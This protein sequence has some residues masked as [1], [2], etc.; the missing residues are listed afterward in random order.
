MGTRNYYDVIAANLPAELGTKLRSLPDELVPTIDTVFRL[1]SGDI[2][3][4]SASGS[5]RTS[6]TK[7]QQ[8]I[9]GAIEHSTTSSKRS[10][11]DDAED[12]RTTKKVKPSAGAALPE[13]E[14]PALF[15][16]NALSLTAPIRKKADITVHRQTLRLTHPTTH[17]AE[18]PPIPLSGFR[19]AFLLP[20]RGKTKPHWTVLL[21]PSDAPAPTGKAAAK[22]PPADA[23]QIAF[24]LDAT[25]PGLTTTAHTEADATVTTHPKGSLALPSLRTFLAHLPI[26]TLEPSTTVFRSAAAAGEPVAGVEAYRGAKSG[27]LWFLDEGVLWD[28]RPAE[29]WPLAELAPGEEGAEGVRTISAT[30]RMCSIILRRLVGKGKTE[31]DEGEEEG[32]KVESVDVDFGMVDG[33]EQE[34]IARWVKCRRQ[35]FGKRNELVTADAKGKGKGKEKVV[36][37]PVEDDD[38]SED[39]DFSLGS[40]GSDGGS[41]TSDSGS[42]DGSGADGDDKSEELGSGS[43]LS[44]DEAEAEGGDEGDDE[45]LDPAHHPLLRPGAM[46]KHISRAAL[47]AVVGMVEADMTDGRKGPTDDQVEESES[48][49][50]DELED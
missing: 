10:R 47:D 31:G 12:A 16:L 14:D 4:S 8:D 24:G 41:A 34:G 42:E 38:D 18:H 15:T 9:S 30:G 19:R 39:E 17:A 45:E 25:P 40:E 29:F 23:P 1:I 48:E 26:P 35:L 6:W 3:P 50:E 36:P 21:M 28:G 5:L 2:C 49:E 27:T 33:K 43:E 22:E 11:E 46:P 37:I 7:A 13:E 20:T 44:D 32:E